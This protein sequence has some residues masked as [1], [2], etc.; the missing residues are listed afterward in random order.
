[1]ETPSANGGYNNENPLRAESPLEARVINERIL[2]AWKDHPRR[3]IIS[4]TTDFLDKAVATLKGIA[5]E[6]ATCCH[7]RLPTHH[8]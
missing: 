2:D 3:S 7:G 4:S 5:A 8:T 1:M 6:L